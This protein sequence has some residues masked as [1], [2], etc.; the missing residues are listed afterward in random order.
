MLDDR[1]QSMSQFVQ[2]EPLSSTTWEPLWCRSR[3]HD[4]ESQ[5]RNPMHPQTRLSIS[6][7]RSTQDVPV[8]EWVNVLRVSEWRTWRSN[9]TYEK[10][11]T[12]RFR[13]WIVIRF[14]STSQQGFREDRVRR[15]RTLRALFLVTCSNDQFKMRV[16]SY[17]WW[18]VVLKCFDCNFHGTRHCSLQTKK[19]VIEIHECVG[20]F[21]TL[22]VRVELLHQGFHQSL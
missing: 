21:R 12:N 15:H 3:S 2:S 20:V 8:F 18:R 5:T 16:E 10:I 17:H 1:I 11:G 19:W 13:V 14:E 4:S 7:N 22:L 6:R 9:T